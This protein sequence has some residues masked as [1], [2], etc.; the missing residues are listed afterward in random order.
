MTYLPYIIG[1]YS[2]FAVVLAWDGLAPLL[3]YRRLIRAIRMRT[4]REQK[5]Q[6]HRVG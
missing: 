1:A 4:M 6:H 5:T 2:V 3:K